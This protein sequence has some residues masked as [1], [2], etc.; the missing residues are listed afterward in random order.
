MFFSQAGEKL[1]ALSRLKGIGEKTLSSLKK[2]H[3]FLEMNIEDVLAKSFD[4]KNIYSK[5][6]LENAFDFAKRQHDLCLSK[7]IS[8]YTMFDKEYPR[9]LIKLQSTPPFIFSK[10][11]FSSLNE[12][13][14]AVI[15]TR[16]PT[17]KGEEIARRITEWIVKNGFNIVSGLAH[18]I[19]SI[20]HKNT[21]SLHGKTIAVMAHGLDMVYP[22]AN[23]LLAS[24]ILENKGALVSEYP[25]GVNVNP[26]NLVK[27][28]A[29]Q[30]ALSSGV[31][32][33]QT[34]LKGGSL[35]A[36]RAILKYGR[37]LIV[38]GQAKTDINNKEDKIS[39]NLALL[40]REIHEI[41]SL[42]RVNN[43]DPKLLVKLNSHLDYH[44]VLISIRDN[45]FI[46]GLSDG[47][48]NE[49]DF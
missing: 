35:H 23:E 16:K 31:F 14:V 22:K 3:N 4:K 24:E 7:N 21:L 25:V 26:I 45:L 30:A 46:Q 10:G 48:N 18:G 33:I 1:L 17:S 29:I 37:P 44:N 49:F 12:N 13:N 9:S 20:A 27:R 28:D 11:N 8:F 15:G 40:N 41:R 19:D 47:E 43:F 38:V 2:E 6:E 42:L 34:G 39:G 32:L 36:S 5:V